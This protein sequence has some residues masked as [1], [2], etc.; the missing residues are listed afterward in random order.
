MK[1]ISVI[2]P[3]Y[4]SAQF[5][6]QCLDSIAAQT[7]TNLEIICIDDCSTD[8]SRQILSEYAAKDNRFITIFNKQNIGDAL[9]RNIGMDTA[10]GEYIYFMD[11]DDWI[12]PDYLE[13]ML[14]VSNRVDTDIVLNL[15]IVQET[16]EKS[17]PY[18]YA[19]NVK[20][21]PDGEFWNKEK[22]IVDSP[23]LLWAR[24]YK[25]DF[26]EKHHLRLS[27]IRTTCD[28]FIFHY[29]S[30]IYADK[31]FLFYGSV[32]HYRLRGDSITGLA[33]AQKSWDLQF[34]KAYDAIYDYYNKHGFLKNCPL[35]LFNMMSF[36]A[37]DSE[38]KF[39]FYHAFF[40]K[41]EPYFR[42]NE[43]LYNEMDKHFRKII[44]DCKDYNEYRT[45]H[46]ANV[47]V[48]Y[49]RNRK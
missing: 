35:K 12:E 38:E 10:K 19:D 14:A 21:N 46:I 37:V 25:R 49:L 3:V 48:D 31:T 26:L 27:A 32:Y 9:T 39:N 13:N 1:L 7:H 47:T 43:Q 20:I 30:N 44:L 23:C 16:P 24:L 15:N 17:Q 36:F 29:I 11:S 42:E 4:N 22:V 41:I 45:K 2:V 5:L 8:K 18:Q 40:N 34:M 6:P 28:D 33:K